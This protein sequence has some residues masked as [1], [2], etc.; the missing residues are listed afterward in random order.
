MTEQVEMR[1]C[2]RHGGD[3]L[4]ITDFPRNKNVPGG[5]DRMC[6]TCWK[7]RPK[8]TFT[9]ADHARLKAESK[10]EK[11]NP[12][13]QQVSPEMEKF[14][15]GLE[16]VHLSK[17]SN[18]PGDRKFFEWSGKNMTEGLMRYKTMY[19]IDARIV[20]TFSGSFPRYFIG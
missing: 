2:R 20:Y 13:A 6:K 8:K 5:Y 10:R 1:V 4:P 9:G 16:K 19:G 17:L 12:T 14:I 11:E 15:A 7:N 3:P 18:L